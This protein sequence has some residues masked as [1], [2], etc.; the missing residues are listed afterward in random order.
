MLLFLAHF[1]VRCD[2]PPLERFLEVLLEKR[3]FLC[4]KFSH[5]MK[6]FSFVEGLFMLTIYLA[7][8]RF[9]LSFSEHDADSSD[10]QIYD[11]TLK[12]MSSC[13]CMNRPQN[14]SFLPLHLVATSSLA[15]LW[16]FPHVFILRLVVFLLS[17][18]NTKKV[19]P[20][21]K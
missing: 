9:F 5:K 6:D 4:F 2:E 18:Q 16:C 15:F 20:R 7:D 17:S 13:V 1:L 8:L 10:C 3:L 14:R 12:T 21:K 11:S 19:S